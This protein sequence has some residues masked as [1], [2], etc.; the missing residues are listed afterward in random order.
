ML[1]PEAVYVRV[2]TC[3]DLASSCPPYR[4]IASSTETHN[5][6]PKVGKDIA[7]VFADGG[8]PMTSA[9]TSSCASTIFAII[10]IG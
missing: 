6:V 1:T 2:S 3:R 5:T 4:P 7:V 10:A 9:Y 8:L